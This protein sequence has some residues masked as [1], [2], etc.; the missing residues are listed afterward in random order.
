MFTFKPWLYLNLG[1]FNL[2][3]VCLHLGGLFAGSGAQSFVND[4]VSD[5]KTC[6][7]LLLLMA[8]IALGIH[9]NKNQEV[10]QWSSHFLIIFF[11]ETLLA[12]LQY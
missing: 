6:S 2:N 12:S 4:V 1:C 8:A 11:G 10:K 7:D 5:L 3:L 9:F